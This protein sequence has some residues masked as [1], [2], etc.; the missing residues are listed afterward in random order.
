VDGYQPLRREVCL[1][2]SEADMFQA[3]VMNAGRGRR[4][5]LGDQAL[6]LSGA[7]VC[8]LEVLLVV[9]GAAHGIRRSRRPVRRVTV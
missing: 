2:V 9:T 5:F 8:S 3:T 4:Y 1:F 7:V 6:I